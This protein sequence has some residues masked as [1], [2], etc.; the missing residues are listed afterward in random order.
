MKKVLKFLLL[1]KEFEKKD[2]DGELVLTML[3]P[4]WWNPVVI[5]GFG[6][7]YLCVLSWIFIAAIPGVFIGLVRMTRVLF[8]T[9][10]E[11]YLWDIRPVGH[12]VLNRVQCIRCGD[13]LT[14]YY[15]HDFKTCSCGT[16]SVD[17]GLDGARTLF[18]KPTDYADLRVYSNEPFEKVR[19]HAYRG[20][21][22]K[23]GKEPLKQIT[24]CDMTNN[25]LKAV[26]EYGGPKWHIGLM[27]KELAYRAAKGIY[28]PDEDEIVN[29]SEGKV[30]FVNL[31]QKCGMDLSPC[32]GCTPI[33]NLSKEECGGIILSKET[34]KEWP[35][36]VKRNP[37]K[38][39]K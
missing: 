38:T 30:R 23:S 8:S 14:S 27:H 20:G 19:Q 37:A 32:E 22:G 25:H 12:M 17:G 39:K 6:L 4:I 9:V 18:N 35:T 3:K 31:C 21:R 26:I 13:I 36:N 28:I 15:N 33:C 1:A 11:G 7:A 2:D 10:N 16:V 5:V 34:L 29:S 24:L